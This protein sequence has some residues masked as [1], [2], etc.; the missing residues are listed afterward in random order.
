MAVRGAQKLPRQAAG[1]W[2]DFMAAAA[3]LAARR[4]LVP[5]PALGPLA[6]RQLQDYGHGR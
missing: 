4:A 6:A 3:V 1:L 5:V 2:W